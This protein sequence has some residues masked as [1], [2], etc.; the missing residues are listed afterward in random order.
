MDDK[1]DGR[2]ERGGRGEVDNG[3]AT[4]TV[5]TR[6]VRNICVQLLQAWAQILPHQICDTPVIL[7]SW[8]GLTQGYPL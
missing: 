5:P 7:L 3:Q 6:R 8:E 2:R 1:G 4:E